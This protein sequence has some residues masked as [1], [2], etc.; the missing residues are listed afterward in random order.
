MD[1]KL[2]E[3][4][5]KIRILRAEMLN[6]EDNIRKQVNRD[7]ECSEA[8]VHLMSM[9]VTMLGLSGERNRLG[10]EERSDPFQQL[11][12]HPGRRAHAPDGAARN[13]A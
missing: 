1:N 4:C 2:N 13:E 10:G 8:A 3:I 9:R 12:L 7:E 11:A 6:A 5:R